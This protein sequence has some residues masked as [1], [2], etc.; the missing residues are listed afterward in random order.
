MIKQYITDTGNFRSNILHWFEIYKRKLPWRNKRTW[1]TV[2]ISEIMLQQTQVRQVIP[3]YLRFMKKFPT[4]QKLAAARRETVLKVWSG[5]GYYSRAR[6]AHH[7]AKIIVSRYGG[8]LPQTARALSNL[9]GFGPYTTNAVLS[10]AFHQPLAVVDGNIARVISR[11][12]MIKDDP[13]LLQTRKKI[14]LIVNGLIDVNNPGLFNEALMELGS[15]VCVP[16]H[17]Q[18]S[19]CPCPIF[20]AAYRR[21]VVENFPVKSR[22]FLKPTVKNIILVTRNSNKFLVVRRPASGLLGGMWEFPAFMLA[23]QSTADSRSWKKPLKKIG[24][25]GNLIKKLPEI[26]HTYSH[27]RVHLFPYYLHTRQLTVDTLTYETY[28]W[29]SWQVLQ[30]L[31]IHRAVQKIIMKIESESI[32]VSKR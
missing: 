10:I 20:C 8:R 1:Y 16:V 31:P 24:L 13:R 25:T 4:V 27:F 26:Y 29:V 5:L 23:E 21:Q 2:W 17:P 14:Q 30:N 15:T 3:Y 32:A 6:N 18:C 19:R 7:A 11:L 9:P 12:L 28:R 22:R